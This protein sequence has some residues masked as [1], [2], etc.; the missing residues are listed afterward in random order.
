MPEFTD[1]MNH[2]ISLEHIP[3]RIISLVP[4]QTELLADL[5][6]EDE[7]VGLTK[8]CIH[9]QQWFQHKTRIGGTKEFDFEKIKLLNPD[10]IIGNKEENEKGQI[11]ELM[12]SYPV[13][14]SDIKTLPDAYEMI[15]KIGELTGKKEKA[16]EYVSELK[17]RFNYF[18]ENV[19]V[20][21]KKNIAYLIWKNPWMAAGK[22]TFIDHLIGKCGLVNIFTAAES[23]Y[24]EIE[25]DE[26]AARNPEIIFL[27]SEPY[28]FKQKHIEELSVVCPKTKIVLVNGELF[29][30]YG[31]RLLKSPKYLIDLMRQFT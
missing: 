13:W 8:F 28:P 27:S 29:S 5:G 9:P 7:V 24:P 6:L 31:T 12:K 22:N 26:L 4:S 3:R 20:T 2:T 11:D 1:Q 17:T 16:I 21:S 30:W 19:N 10:L 15:S 14:M 18:Q 25:I 23:R